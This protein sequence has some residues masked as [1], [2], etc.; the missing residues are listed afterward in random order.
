MA[1]SLSE[2]VAKK[3]F[4]R[5]VISLASPDAILARSHGEITKPET[6]NYRS[7]RPEKDGLFCEKIFGPVKDWECTRESY[8]IDAASK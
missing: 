8:A 1:Y 3:G 2:N 5:I 4:S 7:F 6:I